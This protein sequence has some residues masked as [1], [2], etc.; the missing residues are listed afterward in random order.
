MKIIHYIWIIKETIKALKKLLSGYIKSGFRPSYLNRLLEEK[1]SEKP[2]DIYLKKYGNKNPDKFFCVIRL[3]PEWIPTAGFFALFNRTL[4]ALYYADYYSFTPIIDNWNL[5]AYEE[6]EKIN[7]TYNVFEYYFEPVS[8]FS[9]VQ[10]LQSRNTVMLKDINADLIL[11]H[12]NMS[13]WYIPTSI[14]I[15]KL[16]QIYN[17]YIKLNQST[18]KMLCEDYKKLKLSGKTLGIHYRGTDYKLGVQNHPK[19]YSLEAFKIAIDKIIAKNKIDSIFLATD[20][21]EALE[22]FCKYYPQTRFYTNTLRSDGNVS[23]AFMESSRKSNNYYLGYEVLRDMITLS[24]CNGLVAGFS[25]VS[26]A[27]RICKKANGEDFEILELLNT[28]IVQKGINWMEYFHE[29][30]AKNN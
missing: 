28:D 30:I 23:V 10:A 7:N 19:Q 26:L 18:K 16:A 4:G 9:I 25:Q 5:S 2:E 12:S 21:S 3:H 1:Y 27:A 14:Y 11:K 13:C 15:D 20:D 8:E 22:F 24:C 17:K 29:N 6:E